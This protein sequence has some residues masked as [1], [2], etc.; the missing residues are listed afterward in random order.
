[1]ID[2]SMF[3][4]SESIIFT[5][6]LLG[7]GLGFGLFGFFVFFSRSCFNI[8]TKLARNDLNLLGVHI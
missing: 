6:K 5:V 1:M 2:L 3:K 8:S 4:H 7:F